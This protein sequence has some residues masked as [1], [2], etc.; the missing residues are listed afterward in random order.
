[1]TLFPKMTKWYKFDPTLIEYLLC[2][3]KQLDYG[4]EELMF[5]SL[6]AHDL[7]KNRENYINSPARW[8]TGVCYLISKQYVTEVGGKR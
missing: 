4:T 3:G 6:D 1:M 2:V 8:Q 7:V 5:W